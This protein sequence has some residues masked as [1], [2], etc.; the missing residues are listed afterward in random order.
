[1]QNSLLGSSGMFLYSDLTIV[2]LAS[3][4]CACDNMN[5]NLTRNG[6]SQAISMMK[7]ASTI[8]M[9][10]VSNPNIIAQDAEEMH[11]KALLQ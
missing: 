6:N 11:S 2:K 7:V 9:S 5:L 3:I 1:M 8:R 10:G 4:T